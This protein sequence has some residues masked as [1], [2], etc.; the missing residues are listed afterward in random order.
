[1]SPEWAYNLLL[2]I[3]SL[4]N[5]ESRSSELLNEYEHQ[6]NKKK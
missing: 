5:K 3:L 6:I 2:L 4:M 1:M